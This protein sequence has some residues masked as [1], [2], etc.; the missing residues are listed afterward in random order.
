M[1]PKQILVNANVTENI[2]VE[3]RD[4]QR[5]LLIGNRLIN[6]TAWM[7][8][9]IYTDS[10]KVDYDAICEMYPY[11]IDEFG[12][13]MDIIKIY[14]AKEIVSI[15]DTFDYDN[16]DLLLSVKEITISVWN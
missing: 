3:R 10:L 11:I 8:L 16:L 6:E 12:D 4:G 1:T 7:D 13:W 2:V 9:S 14:K 5:F 15:T